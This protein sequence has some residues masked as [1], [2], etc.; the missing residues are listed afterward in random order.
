MDIYV[1]YFDSRE[2]AHEEVRRRKSEAVEN[3]MVVYCEKTG[4]GNWKVY[5]T[6]ADIMVDGLADGPSRLPF[7]Q[8]SWTKR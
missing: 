6:P 1:C 3:G 2:E 5:S 8:A 4:Y 7:R